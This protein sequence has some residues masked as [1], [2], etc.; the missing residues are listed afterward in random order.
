MTQMLLLVAVLAVHAAMPQGGDRP[1]LVNFTNKYSQW[2]RLDWTTDRVTYVGDMPVQDGAHAFFQSV[3]AGFSCI[4]GSVVPAGPK[5]HRHTPDETRLRRLEFISVDG[6]MAVV[7]DLE[8][9]SS[10][11][12]QGNFPVDERGRAFFV[13]LW[14]S[15]KSCFVK[16]QKAN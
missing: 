11:R 7:V 2:G 3:Y 1:H 6:T 14:Q 8:K 12:Y 15:Y 5:D 4:D 13:F 9:P 10:P 16:T